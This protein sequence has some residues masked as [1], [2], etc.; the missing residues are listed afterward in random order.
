M[1]SNAE[2]GDTKEICGKHQEQRILNY[3]FLS[4][5]GPGPVLV[6]ALRKSQF[7]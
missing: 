4:R 1:K 2:A 6:I 3:H 7:P 5:P